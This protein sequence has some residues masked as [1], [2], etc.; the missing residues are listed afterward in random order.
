VLLRDL[1]SGA[2]LEYELVGTLEADP[3][4]GRI[5][6]A[7]PIGRALLGRRPGEVAVVEVPKGRRRFEILAVG[8]PT[9]AG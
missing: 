8:Q 6:A 9:A 7:S 3:T 5:S 2:S 4:A 1:E